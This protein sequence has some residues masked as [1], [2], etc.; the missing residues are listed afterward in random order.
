MLVWPKRA[1][2]AIRKLFEPLQDIDVYVEDTQDEPLY[3]CL[4]NHATKGEVRVA[5]VFGLG[6]RDAVIAKATTHDHT[7]RRAL[8]II[9]QDLRWARGEQ[10]P[11]IV[12]LH[13]HDAYCVEN[14]L[15]CERALSSILAQD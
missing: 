8:F 12:G 15:L 4:V 10:P 6:G 11:A 5:R 7:M 3:R 14:L 13:C 2:A 9:D 1:G